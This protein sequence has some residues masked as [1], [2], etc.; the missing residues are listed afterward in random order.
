MLARMSLIRSS[1]PE[2][3][4]GASFGVGAFLI[5]VGLGG[6]TGAIGPMVAVGLLL[7]FAIAFLE[8]KIV[9]GLTVFATTFTHLGLVVPA[10]GFNLRPESLLI[11][12]ALLSLLIAG[13]LGLFVNQLARPFVLVLTL[14]VAANALS[15]ALFSVEKSASFGVVLWYAQ[16]L[17]VVMIALTLWG[18]DREGLLRILKAGV[19]ISV[20][21]GLLG[22]LSASAGGPEWGAIADPSGGVRAQGVSAEPNILAAYVAIWVIIFLTQRE[23]LTRWDVLLLAASVAVVFLTTT[24]AAIL[25]L[26]VGLVFA[27]VRSGL[28]SRR[29]I[30]MLWL[31]GIGAAVLLF[32]AP[33]IGSSSFSKLTDFQFSNQTSTLRFD[34]WQQG[35]D[36]LDRDN[37]LLGL[38]TN[39][40]GQRHMLLT[41]ATKQG[42]LGNLLLQGVYDVGLTGLGLMLV[43]GFIL[44]RDGNTAAS[45]G[46]RVAVLLAFLVVASA[47]NPSFLAC[48]WLVGALALTRA[49]TDVADEVQAGIAEKSSIK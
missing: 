40:Y 36:D 33:D 45:R 42:Y 34:T 17:V 35:L 12:A 46:R 26:I 15:S 20:I 4:R 19:A 24:R 16:D 29:I 22:Y 10:G 44:I 31:T 5:L 18:S 13:K 1:L 37:V 27:G 41:D 6:L 30:P 7:T 2:S 39:S 47:T 3:E 14:Y 25:A 9:C 21:T 32:L 11:P 43:V 8:P 28:G 38:G 48:F 49:K 23:R